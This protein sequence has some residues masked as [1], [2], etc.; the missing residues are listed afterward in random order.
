MNFVNITVHE[1]DAS[2]L[3]VVSF[4]QN[5]PLAYHYKKRIFIAA[6]GSPSEYARY[7]E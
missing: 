5:V 7:G 3:N 4:Q 2:N 6:E 1:C